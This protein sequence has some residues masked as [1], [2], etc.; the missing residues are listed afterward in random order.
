MNNDIS[1]L[2]NAHE[3]LNLNKY[4]N[5]WN[6]IGLFNFDFDFEGFSG[7]DFNSY[8]ALYN[9]EYDDDNLSGTKEEKELLDNHM[10]SVILVCGVEENYMTRVKK[11]NLNKINNT[12]TQDQLIK[13]ER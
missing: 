9:K 3:F 2:E 6:F 11:K 12:I 4:M 10:Y 8:Y 7:I 1:I 5:S 13:I